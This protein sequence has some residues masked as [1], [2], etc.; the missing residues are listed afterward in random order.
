ML[1]YKEKDVK[2]VYPQC[3]FFE[4]FSGKLH[5]F[6]NSK[7]T[8]VYLFVLRISFFFFKNWVGGGKK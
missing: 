4:C 1:I 7:A 2:R 3:I 6:E 8:E 5:V